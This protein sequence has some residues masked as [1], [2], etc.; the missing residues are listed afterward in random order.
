MPSCCSCNEN[1]V[2]KCCV[3][4]CARRP[5]ASCFPLGTGKCV[6]SLANC[7]ERFFSTKSLTDVGTSAVHIS[8]GATNCIDDALCCDST[9][10]IQVN[11]SHDTSCASSS[12]SST[13]DL[14]IYNL[15]NRVYDVTLIN[16]DSGGQDTPWC[17]RWARIIQHSGSHYTLP[18][19]SV[20]QRYVDLLVN[21][22][23]YLVTGNYLSERV[24][25]CG[26]VI[27]RRDKSVKKGADVCCLLE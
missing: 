7:Q 17:I 26:S 10:S 1:A 21:E 9:T 13:S 5:C 4:A 14:F 8:L 12:L 24:L 19:G 20:G 11:V 23:N 27:L 22:V 3:C 6:N 25:V 16:S 15:M 18:G 2:C